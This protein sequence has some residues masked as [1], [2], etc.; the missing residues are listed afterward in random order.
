[1]MVKRKFR[2]VEVS[3]ICKVVMKVTRMCR[4][5]M[6]VTRKCREIMIRRV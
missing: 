1:M 5:I 3:R 2:A 6:R 4:K